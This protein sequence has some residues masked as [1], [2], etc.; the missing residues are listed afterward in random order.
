MHFS[1][2]IRPIDHDHDLAVLTALIH[3]AYA[4]HA[5]KGLRYWGTHQTVQDTARRLASGQGFVAESEG[6]MLGTVL[7]RAPQPDSPVALYQDSTTWSICQLAVSPQFK[8]HG[9]GRAL[10]DAALAHVAAHGGKNTALDT[11][12][13]ALGLIRLYR[14]WGYE[15]VGEQDWRPHT[16]YLS[17]LMRRP[18]SAQP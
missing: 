13:P 9:I 10:H 5:E 2:T 6:E 16:N 7:V 3:A 18:L 12:A 4:P 14:A 1:L 17:V 15:I 8:G 11:A